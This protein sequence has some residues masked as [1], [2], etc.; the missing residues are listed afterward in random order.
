MVVLQNCVDLQKVVP[1]SDSESCHD[2]SEVIDIKTENVTDV[3]EDELPV[4]IAFPEIK[5]EEE[6]C[7]IIHC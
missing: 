1:G 6:V 2:G 3:E 5:D 4:L 7:L